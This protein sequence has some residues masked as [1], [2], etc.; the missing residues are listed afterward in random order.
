MARKHWLQIIGEEVR[1]RAYEAV[2]DVAASMKDSVPF[3]YP[4]P[5]PPQMHL[6]D[7]LAAAPDMRLAYLQ[8]LD[9]KSFGETISR[10][11]SEAVDKFGAMAQAV[12]PLLAAD[13]AQIGAAR[14]MS[15]GSDAGLGTQ[16]AYA[17]LT[18]LLGFDPFSS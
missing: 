5:A 6:G 16:A 17:E 12:T 2:A 14:L 1:D 4:P 9:G 11:Q 18:E 3:G 15:E 10:L 8:S 7:Y 13:E